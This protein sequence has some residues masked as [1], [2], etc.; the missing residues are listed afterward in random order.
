LRAMRGLCS[1][2]RPLH[3]SLARQTSGRGREATH[4]AKAREE[5][6]APPAA[7]NARLGKFAA[8]R[9]GA[10]GDNRWRRYASGLGGS[11]VLP[12]SAVLLFA[13]IQ[14]WRGQRAG[15]TAH[16]L[17]GHGQRYLQHQ[18]RTGRRWVPQ[19]NYR[20]PITSVTISWMWIGVKISGTTYYYDPAGKTFPPGVPGSGY[21]TRSSGIPLATAMGYSSS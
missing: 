14:D 3:R 19:Y 10:S 16:R 1:G 11:D 21:Q 2:S 5:N 12:A 4:S 15:L 20:S 9:R 7:Q 17:V 6:G 8:T 18:L 13:A